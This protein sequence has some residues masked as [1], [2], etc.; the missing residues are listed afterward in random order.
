MEPLTTRREESD[1]GECECEK[2]NKQNRFSHDLK[3][4]TINQLASDFPSA[5]DYDELCKKREKVKTE[6]IE[7]VGDS[8]RSCTRKQKSI[9]T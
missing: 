7:N 4:I 1:V 5:S 3:N 9:K 6:R 2:R 8:L